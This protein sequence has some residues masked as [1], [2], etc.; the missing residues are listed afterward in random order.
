ML[1]TDLTSEQLVMLAIPALPNLFALRH[2]MHHDFPT[3]KMKVRWMTACIFLPCIGGIAYYLVGK[4]HASKEKINVFER[5]GKKKPGEAVESSAAQE[6]VEL[7]EAAVEEAVAMPSVQE[8]EARS[9]GRAR[10]PW[11]APVEAQ[12]EAKPAAGQWDFGCPEDLR[13]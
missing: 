1:I 13:K 10:A 6:A 4:K 12:A 9:E 5:Y 7:P 8:S 2:A 3:E 11:D